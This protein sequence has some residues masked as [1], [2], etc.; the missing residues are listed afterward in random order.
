MLGVKKL[1]PTAPAPSRTAVSSSACRA[2][3]LGSP[4]WPRYAPVLLL[5][6]GLALYANSFNTTFI[7]DDVSITDNNHLHT[8]WPLWRT[9]FAPADLAD[10]GRPV[11]TL[12]L[13]LNYA[14]GGL[15]VGGYRA[16]NIAIH[17]LASLVL[18]GVMR[19]T[20]L[21]PALRDRFGPASAALALVVALLWLVHPLQTEC[22]CYT[23]QRSESLMGLFYLLT[24]YCAIREMDS[25]HHRLWRAAAIVACALGMASKEVMVTAPVTV[26]LYDWAFRAQPFNQVLRRRYGL[27]LGLAATW[28]VLA[29]L[30]LGAPRAESVGWGLGTGMLDYALS[31]CVMIATYLRLALWPH[32]LVLDYGPARPTALLETWPY[33]IGLTALLLLVGWTCWRRPRLGFAAAWVF[34]ILAPTSSIIPIATEVGAERRMYL[35]LAGVVVLVVFGVYELLRRWSSPRAAI[36]ASRNESAAASFPRG[37]A[38]ALVVLAIVALGATTIKRNADYRSPVVMWK[39]VIQARPQNARAHFGLANALVAEGRIAEAIPYF[40]DAIR[41]DP[42]DAKALSNLGLALGKLNRMAEAVVEHRRAVQLAPENAE[43]RSRLGYALTRSGQ[44]EEALVEFAAALRLDPTLI[45]AR[46]NMGGAL[47]QLGRPAEAAEHYEEVLRQDPNYLTAHV[48]LG[49]ICLQRDATQKAI[50]HL[51]V[52]NR[53]KRDPELMVFLGQALEAAG[54]ASEA[55]EQYRQ[56]LSVAPGHALAQARLSALGGG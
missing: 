15:D 7:F 44:L 1:R 25:A 16:V 47:A 9:I 35:P 11:V 17:L 36:R 14:A 31:Q 33:L 41:L 12:T 20:L 39:T 43:L 34:I 2:A 23:S 3:K 30:M 26:F 53:L 21:G 50:E 38:I 46:A 29:A 18:Y 28:A 54:R 51:Q 4:G 32:P 40:Q 52:A 6:A 13:L 37:P 45:D 56:A 10:S 48:S 49:L 22:V 24:L 55:V 19:R 8:L 27:Y 42:Q 5:A